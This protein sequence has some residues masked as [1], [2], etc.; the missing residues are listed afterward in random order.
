MSGQDFVELPEVPISRSRAKLPEPGTRFGSWEVVGE[1]DPIHT[2]DRKM[3]RGWSLHTAVLVECQCE[4]RIRRVIKLADLK[5]GK[6]RSCGCLQRAAASKTGRAQA[7][8]GGAGTPEH[9][10]WLAMR[11]RCYLETDAFF[12]QYGGRGI[13]VC[14]AWRDDFAAF[15]AD[16][17]KR[18]S[19]RHTLE[20]LDNDE[21]YEPG[22]CAWVLPRQQAR[23]RRSTL[24]VCYEGKSMS[25]AEAAER[26]CVPYKKAWALHRKGEFCEPVKAGDC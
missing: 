24:W 19:D 17:G 15:I 20:R 7:V 5:A 16:M 9:R 3:R 22:N 2:T 12:A 8:H 26:A 14:D 6:S 25:L 11:R 23:N 18:P 13:T 1:A 21:S 10:I 4:S